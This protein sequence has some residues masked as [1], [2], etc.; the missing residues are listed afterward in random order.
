MASEAPAEVP[1]GRRRVR[2]LLRVLGGI[3]TLLVLIVLGLLLV[4]F[5]QRVD[6]SWRSKVASPRYVRN[7]PGV[8][9]DEG[10]YNAH[11]ASGRYR[12]LERLLLADGYKT[13]RIGDRFGPADLVRC[14]VL[15]VANA[16]GGDRLRLGPINLPIK[17][18]GNRA[19]PA[20]TPLEIRLLTRWVERGGNLLLVADHAPFGQASRALA[21]AFGVVMHGGFA[22]VPTD[23]PA[24]ASMG[25][26]QFTKANGLLRPHPITA[27]LSKIMTF[28][29]QSLSGAGTPLLSLPD[30]A[31]E[32]MP[33][34]PVLRP[35]PAAG[36]SQA[37]ALEAGKGRV[38]VLGEA[39]MLSAQ[40]GERGEKMGM[41]VP[42]NDNQPFALN[43]F[44]WLSR[45]DGAHR[46]SP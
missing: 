7:H 42:G 14:R 15:V 28:T 40:I 1:A 38:V 13:S 29:G 30:N 33:P 16:A 19:D 43:V 45:A 41:N 27:G 24:F 2:I 36:H 6:S 10:H 5:G 26:A 22:E 35:V 31:V 39:G 21:G 46:T 20:F 32:Y 8:C 34:G 9:F 25:S 44:H 17:R 37:V 3:G 18:G 23:S 4:P 12:P 11:K